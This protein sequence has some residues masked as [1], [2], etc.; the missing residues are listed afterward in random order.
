MNYD[1]KKSAVEEPNRS[2]ENVLRREN[3]ELK[4]QKN[5]NKK[6]NNYI[7]LLSVL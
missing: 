5:N 2:Q 1:R 7:P 3:G 6:K 4:T